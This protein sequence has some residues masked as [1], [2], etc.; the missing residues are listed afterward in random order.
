MSILENVQPKNVFHY[1]EEICQIPHGSYHTKQ[2][3]DYLAAFA[4]EHELEY[5]QDDLNNVV[6]IKEATAVPP[7]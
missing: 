1:F 5:Y 7:G 3:S 2:I 4:K 6:M